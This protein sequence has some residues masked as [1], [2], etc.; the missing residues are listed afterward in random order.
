VNYCQALKNLKKYLKN[1]EED[2]LAMRPSPAVATRI[3]RR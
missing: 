2:E 3:P 1:E